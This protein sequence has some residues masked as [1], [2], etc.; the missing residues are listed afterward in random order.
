MKED[1]LR[2]LCAEKAMEYIKN[3]TIIG[4]GAGR[5]ISCLIELISKAAEDN[6]K[7]KVVTPSDNT[8]NICIIRWNIS[9]SMFCRLS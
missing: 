7:V 6:L 1:N 3:N 9:T 8:K 5:N 2:R 4:L